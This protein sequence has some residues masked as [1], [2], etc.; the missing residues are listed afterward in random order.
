MQRRTTVGKDLA[1]D[2]LCLG[3]HGF[4]ALA[5][6]LI[7]LGTLD[8]WIVS[9]LFENDGFANQLVDS[10][11]GILI[12]VLEIDHDLVEELLALGDHAH[13]LVLGLN[14][15]LDRRHE[16]GTQTGDI[17]GNT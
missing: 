5:Q 13:A 2:L 15:L 10:F 1:D 17:F 4:E 16:L 6:F 9:P 3:W 11:A 8:A 14:E 7:D 12:E